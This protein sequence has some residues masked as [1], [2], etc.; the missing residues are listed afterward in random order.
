M[1]LD[2]LGLLL[3]VIDLIVRCFQLLVDG[4]IVLHSL[5]I[6]LFF[7]SNDRLVLGGGFHLS[8][9]LFGFLYLL[10]LL[11]YLGINLLDVV[12]QGFTHVGLQLQLLLFDIRLRSFRVFL[13]GGKLSLLLP[14][15]PI[16]LRLF[17]F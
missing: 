6:G 17:L 11:G 4:L 7:L 16:S 14:D 9:F 5:I 13:H 1:L 10:L 3:I 12:V 15:P 8:L 2:L